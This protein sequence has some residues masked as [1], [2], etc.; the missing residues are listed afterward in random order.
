MES[1]EKCEAIIQHFN[2]KFIKT[3]PGVPGV[4]N[5]F[6]ESDIF[7][8]VQK[9]SNVLSPSRCL[10]PRPL[11]SISLFVF[12]ISHS[13]HRTLVSE[14]CRRWTEEEAESGEVPSEWKTLGQRR[15]HGN[16][17]KLSALR[18]ELV[19]FVRVLYKGYLD[20]TSVCV[21]VCVQSE[22]ICTHCASVC[23]TSLVLNS[24]CC[25]S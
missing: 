9:P 12:F 10:P 24:V 7:L 8:S 17:N 19:M 4:W 25:F 5:A 15:R 22:N 14:V 2:G 21:C 13:A 6:W 18:P 11:K 3:P 1:T 20:V 23:M 16:K